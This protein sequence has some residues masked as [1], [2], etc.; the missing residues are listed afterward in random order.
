[1]MLRVSII[2]YCNQLQHI[3]QNIFELTENKVL[4]QLTQ[5]KEVIQI[6]SSSMDVHF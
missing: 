6:S 2:K 5:V 4:K 1:M 3:Y